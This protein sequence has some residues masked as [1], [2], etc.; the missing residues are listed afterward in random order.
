MSRTLCRHCNTRY[1]NRPRG[2]CGQCYYT[3]GVSERYPPTSK[4]AAAAPKTAS[5]AD[6]HEWYVVGV[7][8]DGRRTVIEGRPREEAAVALARRLCAGGIEYAEIDVERH[9][10]PPSHRFTPGRPVESAAPQPEEPMTPTPETNGHAE[11]EPLGNHERGRRLRAVIEELGQAAGFKQVVEKLEA[12]GL[13]GCAY[14][15]WQGHRRALGWATTRVGPRKP[16]SKPA[17]RP[18]PRPDGPP[19]AE[20]VRA[21][22]PAPAAAPTDAL[23]LVL[24]DRTVRRLGGLAEARRLLGL[25]AGLEG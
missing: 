8:E 4:Y 11:P 12:V 1:A 3:P 6:A 13:G 15:S 22:E 10:Q 16:P 24:L 9:L 18:Q 19:R 7:D 14:S 21:P 20:P 2:L 23:S 17:P 25:L 5:A